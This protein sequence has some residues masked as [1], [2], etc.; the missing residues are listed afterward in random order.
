MRTTTGSCTAAGSDDGAAP[1]RSQAC[2]SNGSTRARPLRIRELARR[3]GFS[4]KAVRFYE[5]RASLS[6]PG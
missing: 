6:L 1:S 3:S 4:I 2:D 5:Q